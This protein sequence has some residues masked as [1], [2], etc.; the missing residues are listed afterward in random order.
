[1][2]GIHEQKPRVGLMAYPRWE[3]HTAGA[4]IVQIHTRDYGVLYICRA[5]AKR[6]VSRNGGI[7]MC[8]GCTII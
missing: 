3:R 1:M 2:L 7:V 5:E 8:R 6:H 4:E